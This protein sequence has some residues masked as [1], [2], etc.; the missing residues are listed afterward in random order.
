MNAVA[1]MTSDAVKKSPVTLRSRTWGLYTPASSP[2]TCQANPAI[3][4]S[5]R[6]TMV[7]A[8]V[9]MLATMRMAAMPRLLMLWTPSPW[10][11][12][13]VQ[14]PRSTSAR[15]AAAAS[16]RSRRTK[17]KAAHTR[18]SAAAMVTAR[19]KSFDARMMTI[20]AARAA[21]ITTMN[22]EKMRVML[23][24]SPYASTGCS[25]ITIIF[26]CPSAASQ[27]GLPFL[28]MYAPQ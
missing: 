3:A 15:N 21:R 14:S 19:K 28:L 26:L 9:T 4:N 24:A 6:N 5:V 12:I 1:T 25:S 27:P 17:K 23:R 11:A 2:N 22:Q 10:V 18:G 16:K 7:R 13:T 20:P 8:F